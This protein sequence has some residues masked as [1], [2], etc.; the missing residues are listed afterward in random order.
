[1]PDV[2]P[3]QLALAKIEARTQAKALLDAAAQYLVYTVDGEGKAA[4]IAVAAPEVAS[5]GAVAILMRAAALSGIFQMTPPAAP[6][7]S[8]PPSAPATP[9][10]G[11]VQ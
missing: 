8:A 2:T 5:M 11:P 6:A 4:L 10:V 7:T 9:N 1:M 3:E